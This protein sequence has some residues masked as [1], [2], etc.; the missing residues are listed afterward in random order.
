MNYQAIID[1]YYPADSELKHILCTHSRDVAD[2]ALRI[3][4]S[5]PE[6]GADRQFVEEAAM[7]H[8]IGIFKCDADGIK[9]FGTEP[10]ICH[11]IIGANILTDE[12]YPTHARVCER[13][14]GAGI[15]LQQIKER[16]LPLPHH[17][18]LPETIEEVIICYADKFFSKTRL[19]HEKTIEK[20]LE[21]IAKIGEDGAARFVKWSEMFS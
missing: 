2:K 16:Q 11:G 6:L 5:H 20:A 17:D 13:H 4:D 21:S 3:V 15:T 8:D 12:G 10:Y 18:Y 1:K 19:G 7:L 14:T 9:C